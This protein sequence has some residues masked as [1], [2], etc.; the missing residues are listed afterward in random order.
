MTIQHELSTYLYQQI[1]QK[2]IVSLFAAG[3]DP[4]THTLH[5]DIETTSGM[6]NPNDLPKSAARV[7]ETA[8]IA[9]FTGRVH[10]IK[11]PLI[12]FPLHENRLRIFLLW[13][14][15]EKIEICYLHDIMLSTD[16]IA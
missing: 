7:S 9:F 14:S 16:E 5:Y 1:L 11:P 13:A 10:E 4:K 6:E 15:Q 3:F 2:T 8:R 12:R